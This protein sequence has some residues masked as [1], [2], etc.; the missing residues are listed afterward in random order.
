MEVWP[1]KEV[2]S[3]M[4][5]Q[6][7]RGSHAREKKIGLEAADENPTNGVTASHVGRDES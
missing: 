3:V 6:R 4:G 2:F 7:G 5:V 1:V